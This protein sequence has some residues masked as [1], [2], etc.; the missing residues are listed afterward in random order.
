MEA[1]PRVQ[2]LMAALAASGCRPP[3]VSCSPCRGIPAAVAAAW[4][5]ESGVVVC[6]AGATSRARVERGVVHELIHALDH[7]RGARGRG[8]LDAGPLVLVM[9]VLT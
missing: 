9:L 2:A 4:D 5:V 8:M 6:H 7:C 3:P 1:T